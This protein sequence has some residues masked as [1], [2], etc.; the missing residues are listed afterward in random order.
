MKKENDIPTLEYR[1]RLVDMQRKLKGYNYMTLYRYEF[2]KNMKDKDETH[3][4]N[5]WNGRNKDVKVL[6][7]FEYITENLNIV[8]LNLKIK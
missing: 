6:N 1:Q 2:K 8:P 3:L 4:H 5:F 7:Q